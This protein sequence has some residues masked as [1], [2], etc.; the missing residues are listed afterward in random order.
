MS[1]QFIRLL[2]DITLFV[3]ILLGTTDA[4]TAQSILPATTSVMGAKQKNIGP[5]SDPNVVTWEMLGLS[6]T[7]LNGPY[8][9]TYFSFGLP[10][11]WKL[12]EGATL[13][14]SLGVFVNAGIQTQSTPAVTSL[15]QSY[16]AG[17]IGGGTLTVY[18]NSTILTVLPLDQVGE[19]EKTIQIPLEAFTSASNDG[20][21]NVSII[22]NTGASCYNFSQTNV[23]IRT[24]SYF[25]LPHELVQPDTSL[26]NFPRPIYQ[27]SFIPSLALI[28]IPDQPSAADLQAALTV[29]IGLNKLSFG[30]VAIDMVTL[31]KLTPEQEA[32]N[33]LIFVGTS[34]SLPI[35]GQMQLPLPVDGGKFKVSGGGSDDGLVEM[36]NSPWNKADVILVVSGNTDQGTIKAAQAVSTGVFRPN[37]FP[38]LAVVQEVQTTPV[39]TPQPTDQTLSSLGYKGRLFESRGV[40][41]VSYN[42]NIPPGWMV[43]SDAN[44]GLVFGH[45]ALIDYNSSGIVV[46]LNGKPIGSVRMSDAS[47]SLSTNRILINIPASAVIPGKNRLEVR[48]NL[49]PKDECSPQN[50]HG[51]WV[52]IWPESMLH[53]PLELTPINSVSNLSLASYPAPFIYYPLLDNTAFVLQHNDLE[54]WQAALKIAT[55]LGSNAN[56][57]VTAL[58]VYYGD[59]L[60]EAERSKYNLLIIGRP[61]QTPI[62]GEINKTLPIP[63][64]SGSDVLADGNFQ[65]TYRIPSDSP[66]GY[67]EIMP[68]PWNSDNVILAVL[69]NT[70]QGLS[71]ATSSLIK[72]T[73]RDRLAGNFA[74]INDKQ[75]ITTDTRLAPT[76]KSVPTESA[77]IVVIP[78]NNETTTSTS[79]DQQTTWVFPTFIASVVLI[80]LLSAFVFIRSWSRNRIRNISKKGGRNPGG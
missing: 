11:D 54:S 79:S 77:E 33:H 78:S 60:P 15:G 27:N 8:D 4:V 21:I 29:A 80:V 35:L 12:I 36:V 63:F 41:N 51:L 32:A 31:G 73:L 1:K 44:F 43:T 19:V 55:F 74:V 52:N 53:L 67:M 49:L 10:A 69:G 17:T 58:K 18:L 66:M 3:S 30:N 6:E 76:I 40:G 70:A 9:A 72:P 56:G 24:S 65:V 34:A 37:K 68:S 61:S 71:W 5:V 64:L 46:L 22:L 47:A 57:P 13:N 14:L 2:I 26:L 28:V 7:Q 59:D 48:V 39:P 62:M 23:V 38:N 16:S 42:F 75:I 50:M 20:S 25:T 45:S